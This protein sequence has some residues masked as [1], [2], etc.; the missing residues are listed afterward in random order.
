MLI[1][2]GHVPFGAL[3]VHPFFPI[4]E[5]CLISWTTL[6]PDT[7]K[8]FLHQ[9]PKLSCFS[10]C[11]LVSQASLRNMQFFIWVKRDRFISIKLPSHF[12][13]SNLHFLSE[14]LVYLGRL[15][16]V[17]QGTSALL[18]LAREVGQR[19]VEQRKQLSSG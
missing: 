6:S 10:L 12:M 5:T 15:P 19:H 1:T 2:R 18:F 11:W 9:A 14:S 16:Q 3:T 4:E 17:S 13:Y 8:Q 7:P